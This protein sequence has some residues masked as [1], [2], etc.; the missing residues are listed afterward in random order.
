MPG[1]VPAHPGNGD[2]EFAVELRFHQDPQV[3][4]RQPQLLGVHP[5][6]FIRHVHRLWCVAKARLH[7]FSDAQ[8][9][10]IS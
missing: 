5:G 8:L 2:G 10:L 4:A 6:E 9:A 7:L 1:G 3:L